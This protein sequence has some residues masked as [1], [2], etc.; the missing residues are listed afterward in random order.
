[1][2]WY[3]SRLSIA[4][5]T[6]PYESKSPAH[7]QVVD[8]RKPRNFIDEQ[9]DKQLARLNLP[10]SPACTDAEFIRRAYVDTIGRLAEID[11]TAGFPRGRAPSKRDG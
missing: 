8:H 10:A 7:G 1:M 6:V 2:A 11:E 3:S 9:V 5:I 4:R